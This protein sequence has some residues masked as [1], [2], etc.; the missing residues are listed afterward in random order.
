MNINCLIVPTG[1]GASVGGYAGDANPIARKIAAVSDYLIT[2]PNVV[3]GAALTNIAENV[4]VLEGALLDMFF[5]NKLALRPK[6]NHKIGLVVDCDIRDEDKIITQNVLGAARAFYGLDVQEITW[7]QEPIAAD[8]D[9]IG[10]P[11]TLLAACRK[12]IDEGATA[13]ALMAKLPDAPETQASQNYVRGSGYDPIGLIEAQISHL[14]SREFII[15]SA[16]APILDPP[17]YE[18]I[19]QEGVVNPKV[20]AEF[21]GLSF[22]PSVMQCLKASAAVIP[23]DAALQT[24]IRVDQLNNLI[25]PFDSCNAAPMLNAARYGVELISVKENITNLDDT[26]ESLGLK[27]KLIDSYDDVL[28]YIANSSKCYHGH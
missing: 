21:I 28:G 22:L 5:E 19:L 16:H 13:L 6:V 14:V 11:E 27:H 12:S 17:L 26:A 15:P 4:I 24:D 3:N 25:V 20:A 18:T 7:T 2:H 1:I 9:K 10:N 8:L 23:I